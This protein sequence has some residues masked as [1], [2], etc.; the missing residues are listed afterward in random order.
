MANLYSRLVFELDLSVSHCC[1]AFEVGTCASQRWKE[2]R[3]DE[4][5]FTWK[6]CSRKCAV[7]PLV[8]ST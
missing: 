8:G 4:D 2:L 5:E 6:H 7:I 1:C 3:K